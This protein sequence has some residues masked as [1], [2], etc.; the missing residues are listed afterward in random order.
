MSDAAGMGPSSLD[1]LRFAS[2]SVYI[3]LFDLLCPFLRADLSVI[4]FA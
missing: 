4:W 3:F 1:L 2:S